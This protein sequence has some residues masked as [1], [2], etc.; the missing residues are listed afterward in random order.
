MAVWGVDGEVD[1]GLSMPRIRNHNNMLNYPRMLV[2]LRTRTLVSFVG[3][4]SKSSGV[5]GSPQGNY[6]SLRP[7]DGRKMRLSNSYMSLRMQE[8]LKGQL[9]F[10]GSWHLASD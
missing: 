8:G 2:P 10:L 6:I 5:G 3:S 7:C 1:A 9:G 4:C